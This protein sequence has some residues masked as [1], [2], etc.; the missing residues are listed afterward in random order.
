MEMI[1]N[2]NNLG[3]NVIN[4]IKKTLPKCVDENK[5]FTYNGTHIKAIAFLKGLKHNKLDELKRFLKD[6]G[7]NYDF[8]YECY[9]KNDSY[10]NSSNEYR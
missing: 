7:Y 2:E 8:M 6:A 9:F 10:N 4:Q 3:I 1:L 5:I